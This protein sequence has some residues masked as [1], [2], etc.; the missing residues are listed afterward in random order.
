MTDIIVNVFILSCD[1]TLAVIEINVFFS[2]YSF[3]KLF[4]FYCTVHILHLKY[5]IP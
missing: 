1:F 4:S 5:V 3:M 2:A